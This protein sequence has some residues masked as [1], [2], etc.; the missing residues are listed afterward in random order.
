MDSFLADENTGILVFRTLNNAKLYGTYMPKYTSINRIINAFND[1]YSVNIGEKNRIMLYIRGKNNEIIILNNLDQTLKIPEIIQNQDIKKDNTI[2]SKITDIYVTTESD[3]INGCVGN[4]SLMNPMTSAFKRELAKS[5]KRILVHTLTER[6]ITLNYLHD[7][8]IENIKE[9]LI[10]REGVPLEQQNLI[11]NGKQLDNDRMVS[12]YNI[13]NGSNLHLVLRLRGGMYHE[14]SGR[15][16]NFQPLESSKI[17]NI[18]PDY[19]VHNSD[20]EC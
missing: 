1:N 8:T 15:N 20:N 6:V 12:D 7:M 18:E 16:G 13:Y 2:E 17:I 5:D 14:T 3:V 4:K 11:F 10:E 9:L 19:N